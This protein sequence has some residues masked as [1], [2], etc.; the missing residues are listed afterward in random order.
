[1]IFPQL[2]WDVMQIQCVVNLLFCAGGNQQILVGFYIFLVFLARV[3]PEQ[4]ILIKC[5]SAFAR[6]LTQHNV[7]ILASGEVE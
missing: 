6:P 4:A 3:Q 1:M 7:V 2:W 5:H